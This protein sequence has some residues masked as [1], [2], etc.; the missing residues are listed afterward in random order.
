MTIQTAATINVDAPIAHVFSIAAG[1]DPR[2]LIQ[3]FGP[4]PGINDVKGHDAPWSAIGQQRHFTLSDKSSVSET[5]T[6][7]S[8]PQS[9]SYDISNFTGLFASLVCGARGQWDFTETGPGRTRIDWTYQFSP[10]GVIAEPVLW[11]IVKLF[12]PGYLKSALQR[13]KEKAEDTQ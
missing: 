3:P 2:D 4:L 9:Y 12:W 5:M 10:T 11:F 1:Y 8:Q 13:V 7:I 6:A